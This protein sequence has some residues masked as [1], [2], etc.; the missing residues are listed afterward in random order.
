MDISGHGWTP[1]LVRAM[2]FVNDNGRVINYY[3]PRLVRAMRFVNDNGRVLYTQ[4]GPSNALC[5]RARGGLRLNPSVPCGVGVLRLNP[6]VAC[7]I[8]GL[9]TTESFCTS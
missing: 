1:R 9:I 8:G 4:I 3:T 6:S 7:V 2:R 5:Y